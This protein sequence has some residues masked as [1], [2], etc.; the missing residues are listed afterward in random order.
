MTTQWD[1]QRKITQ[2]SPEIHQWLF[3]IQRLGKTLKAS[4]PDIRLTKLAQFNG[5]MQPDEQSL[6]Q[7]TDADCHIR[8]VS[9]QHEQKHIVLG[10]T[11]I[12]KATYLAYKERFDQLNNHSIGECFLFSHKNIERS[13]FYAKKYASQTIQQLFDFTAPVSEK[14]IWARASIFT[15]DQTHQLLIEEFFLQ[16]PPIKLL[17]P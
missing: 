7:A 10:R 8:L 12:P 17:C 1:T 5:S 6:L 9:H 11:I 15:L 3:E 2:I 14:E 4:L 16:M 13:Q